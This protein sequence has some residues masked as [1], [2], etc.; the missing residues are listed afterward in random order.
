[1]LACCFFLRLSFFVRERKIFCTDQSCF[2]TTAYLCRSSIF[3][4]SLCKQSWILLEIENANLLSNPPP[5]SLRGE[6]VLGLRVLGESTFDGRARVLILIVDLPELGSVQLGLLHELDLVD[7]DGVEGE[8]AGGH[9][10]DL[11]LQGVEHQGGH[12]S[13]HRAGADLG[14]QGLGDLLADL[15]DLRGLGIAEDLVLDEIVC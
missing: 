4:S 12:H 6:R 8:D 9:V 13:L 15:L 14:L 2:T 3:R 5:T 10:L 1:M 11:G 7:V